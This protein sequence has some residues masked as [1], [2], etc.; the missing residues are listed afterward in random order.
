M[1]APCKSQ[2]LKMEQGMKTSSLCEC[3]HR[4]IAP[5]TAARLGGTRHQLER[6]QQQQQQQE[7]E[8]GLRGAGRLTSR[9]R[10]SRP[11][12]QIGRAAAGHWQ[13]RIDIIVWVDTLSIVSPV[14]P[15]VRVQLPARPRAQPLLPQLAQYLLF[16]AVLD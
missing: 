11:D 16:Q 3:S 1:A 4:S 6:A 8:A 7:V 12:R 15:P 9:H 14:R 13:V 10:H 5:R 2:L